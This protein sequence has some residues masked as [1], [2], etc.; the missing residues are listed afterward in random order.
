MN[1]K[2]IAIAIATAMTAPVAMADVKVSGR[3]GGHL[4]IFTHDNSALDSTGFGDAGQTRLQFDATAGDAFARIALDERLGRDNATAASYQRTKRDNY[5]GYNFGNMSASFGRMAGVSK[6]IEKDPLIATFLQSRGTVA[7]P[8]AGGANMGSSS[9]IDHVIT[10]NMKAGDAKIAVQYDVG[11]QSN[12]PNE[13]HTGIAVTGKGGPVNYFFG[14]NNGNA[15]GP[16]GS[17][18]TNDQSNMKVGASMTF[19]KV[20]ATLVYQSADNNGAAQSA[21]TA[22]ANV[23]MGNG[24]SLN[25]AVAVRS[26][27]VAADDATWMRIAVAK[28]LDNNAT[29]Y[30]G[31]T[32]SSYD[33]ANSDHSTLGAGMIVKF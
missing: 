31:Y 20:K 2:L 16:G 13:G 11:D 6:N 27:D 3:V 28:K 30:A 29:A 14:Y 18:P 15:D 24:L 7:E 23:G 9:F 17:T 12:S 8:L 32:A 21:I 25:A 19:G 1:K 10:F 22:R 5:I 26:G 33:T 4:T